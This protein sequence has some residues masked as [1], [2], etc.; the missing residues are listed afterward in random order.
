MHIV[1]PELDR[2]RGYMPWPELNRARVG[3]M[4]DSNGRPLRRTSN[5]LVGNPA[6]LIGDHTNPI[7]K[8]A[9]AEM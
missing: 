5:V 7:W 3:Q 2:H 1:P 8:F 4:F 6:R 9:A